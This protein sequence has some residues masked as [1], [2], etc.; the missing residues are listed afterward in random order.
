MLLL[1]GG[2]AL[3]GFERDRRADELGR[4]DPAVTGV[5]A[6]FLYAVWLHGEADAGATA[7]LHELLAATGAYGHA[8]SHLIV[9][10]R[11]GTISPWSS[12]ATD[13]AHTA[14]LAQV[15]RIERALVW[16]LDGAALPI[17]GELRE[18]L[19]DRMT[20]AV[21]AGPDD[22]ATLMPTGSARDGSHVALGKDG[23]AA[24]R[25][26]NV[27]MGLSLSDPEIAYL[28][29]GFAALGRDPTDTELMMF[30]QAN[31]EHCRHKIFNA[32]W[33]I[34]GVPLDG[35]LFDRIRHTHRSN[36]GRVLVAYSD[37]SAVSAG[38]SADRLLPPPE[39]GSYRYEFEAVNLLM[40]VETHNHPTAIS[41]YPGAATGSGG[42]IRDEGATGIG[43]RPKAGLT[44]FAVSHLRI[45]TLP[46]PWEESAGR[47]SHIASAL[48]IMLDGPIGAARFNN[49]FGRP[50]L[51]GFFRSFE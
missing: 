42:E 33:Q 35:S 4:V 20:E 19:H 5:Q 21:F 41:P 48:D 31:S 51:C 38:Y 2:P 50:A 11:P 27:E 24:L 32:S 39:S 14:G 3:S 9:A 36:P 47:P 26:A 44:G 8:A 34:D 45:P 10:P 23:E 28:A 30:A 12:K 49:E 17:S 29:D 7:R 22:L 40:K 13:I 15:V 37:N 18:L 46:Q 6:D 1:Q 43:R 16:R 25:A